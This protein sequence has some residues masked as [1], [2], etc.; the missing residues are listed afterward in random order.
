[1]TMGSGRTGPVGP[2]SPSPS[3]SFPQPASRPTLFPIW[4][5][6]PFR[7]RVPPP[8]VP[9]LLPTPPGPNRLRVN[10]PCSPQ[11]AGP[12]AGD[13]L[14]QHSAVASKAAAEAA[15]AAAAAA[16]AGWGGGHGGR[17]ALAGRGSLAAESR[18]P[19]RRFPR[20]RRRARLSR[21]ARGGARSG[22][23]GRPAGRPVP[24]QKAWCRQT[25][26]AC[27]ASGVRIFT[28]SGQ[29]SAGAE[30]GAVGRH[31]QVPHSLGTSSGGGGPRDRCSRRPALGARDRPCATQ[32]R[33]AS[34]LE[35]D[36]DSD[37]ARESDRDSKTE[38][39]GLRIR[40]GLLGLWLKLGLLLEL[41]LGLVPSQNQ[42]RFDQAG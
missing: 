41:E 4:H 12:P 8:S 5:R 40:L 26:G 1:M 20:P 16:A 13:Q 34:D 7:V 36:S 23:E 37:S 15:A 18:A 29:T 25:A 22:N 10:G 30:A 33:K 3:P 35:L 11:E 31:P 32:R 19:L 2:S 42:C 9:L 21:A 39:L 17:G 28:V 14:P 38:V 6:L 24:A 27:R